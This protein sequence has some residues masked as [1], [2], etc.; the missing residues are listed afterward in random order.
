[1][2]TGSRPWLRK[3]H[4]QLTNIYYEGEDL[5]KAKVHFEAADMAGNELARYILGV[6]EAQYGNIE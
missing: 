3:A 4:C 6:M 5:K 2:E 1:M